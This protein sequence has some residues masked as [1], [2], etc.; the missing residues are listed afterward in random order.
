MKK[1]SSRFSVG[2][3]ILC[4]VGTSPSPCTSEY[5]A[6]SVNTNPVIIRRI[7]GSLK[8]AGLVHV[9]AGTGGASLR[10]ELDDITLLDVYRAVE[11][12]ENGGLF[13]FHEHP[14]PECPVGANIEAALRTNMIAAQTALENELANVTLAQLVASF[15]RK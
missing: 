10:K 7:M 11:V 2:V 4:V 15:D 8:K 14:N 13:H 9:K 3:H 5:I 1:I 6:A 12:V